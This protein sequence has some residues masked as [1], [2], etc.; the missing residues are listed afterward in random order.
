[1]SFRGLW[2]LKDLAVKRIK[3]VGLKKP[4]EIMLENFSNLARDKSTDQ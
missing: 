3:K 1:M 4:K 2:V